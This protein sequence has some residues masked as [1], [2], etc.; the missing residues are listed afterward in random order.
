MISSPECI[1]SNTVLPCHTEDLKIH[2]CKISYHNLGLKKDHNNSQIFQ[3]KIADLFP[4]YKRIFTDASKDKVK[5]GVGVYSKE[6]ISHVERI[7]NYFSICSA[8]LVAIQRAISYVRLKNIRKALILSDSK[9]ALE[10][11]SNWVPH[12][13][14]DF[15]TL[16]IRKEL[17]NLR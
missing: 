1:H 3:E 14:N 8:E 7:P 9:S 2:Y 5:V 15:L 10:K 13:S 16:Q 11:I 4:D 12:S 6:G 17:C